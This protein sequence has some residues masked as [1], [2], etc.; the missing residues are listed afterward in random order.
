MDI[1]YDC[2]HTLD[3]FQEEYKQR[4]GVAPY[5]SS[6]V[7]DD[8]QTSHLTIREF[9]SDDSQAPFQICY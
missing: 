5:T 8:W 4:F 2:Y 3:D 7:R 1:R 9:W 6:V